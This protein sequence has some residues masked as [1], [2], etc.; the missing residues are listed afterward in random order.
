MPTHTLDSVAQR[1]NQGSVKKA[2]QSYLFIQQL[3]VFSAVTK[4]DV[5]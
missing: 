5:R 2:T 1:D 3:L 4:Q